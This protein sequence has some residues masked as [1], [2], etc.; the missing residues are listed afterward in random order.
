MYYIN[1]NFIKDRFRSFYPVVIDVETAGF[2][3]FTDAILEIGLITLKMNTKG[4][5]KKD[6]ILHFNI[7][8]FKGSILKP[9]ALAFNKIDPMNPSRKAIQEINAIETIFKM[10]NKK[11]DL[12]KCSKAIIVGH[13]V[14]FDHSFIMAAA[15]RSFIKNNPFHPFTTFDTAT[16][17]GL[18]VGETVLAKACEALGLI[19][20]NKKAHSAIYDTMQTANLFCIIINKWKELGGWPSNTVKR[21]KNILNF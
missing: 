5:L 18:A 12:N 3:P 17:S 20:D 14:T 2:N 21:R 11:I 13:N 9:S 4:W 16:L 19:F 10:I 7:K 8:P 1:K 15:A 6:K